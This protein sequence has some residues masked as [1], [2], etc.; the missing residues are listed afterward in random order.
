MEGRTS[1]VDGIGENVGVA[2]VLRVVVGWFPELQSYSLG[3]GE[4]AL[5]SRWPRNEDRGGLAS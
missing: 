1:A 4:K 5:A 3:S 2:I